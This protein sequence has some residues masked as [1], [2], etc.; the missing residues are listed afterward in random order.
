MSETPTAGFIAQ[1]FDE[2]QNSEHAEW[3]NPF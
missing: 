2:V 3:L 1:E